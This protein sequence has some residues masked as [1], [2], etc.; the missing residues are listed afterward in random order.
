MAVFILKRGI[1]S[2][3]LI[4]NFEIILVKSNSVSV[5][6]KKII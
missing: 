6:L 4:K 3:I 5:N 2:V 1:K